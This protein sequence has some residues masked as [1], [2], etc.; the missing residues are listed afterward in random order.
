MNRRY[1][2][3]SRA[4]T[5]VAQREGRPRRKSDFKMDG[6]TAKDLRHL[7]VNEV[8]FGPGTKYAWKREILDSPYEVRDG[9]MRDARKALSSNLA[10]WRKMGAEQKKQILEKRW[11]RMRRRKEKSDGKKSKGNSDDGEGKTA[12]SGLFKLGFRSCKDPSVAEH[13][14]PEE[15]VQPTR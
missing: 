12:S 1:A 8:A 4:A 2:A 9:G 11:A 6:A 3:A 15:A 7:C 14:H 13:R 10:K 5:E